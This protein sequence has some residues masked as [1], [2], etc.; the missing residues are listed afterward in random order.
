MTLS[1]KS[2]SMRLVICAGRSPRGGSRPRARVDNPADDAR[3]TNRGFICCKFTSAVFVGFPDPAALTAYRPVPSAALGRFRPAWPP[4]LDFLREYRPCQARTAPYF[5]RSPDN[6]A[7]VVRE[8]SPRLHQRVVRPNHRSGVSGRSSRFLRRR[9][10][11]KGL[12]S[13]NIECISTAKAPATNILA[14]SRE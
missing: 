12:P 13:L 4:S 9:S 1:S 5:G 8:P 7:A 11:S 6:A 10:L 2:D 14:S 3:S